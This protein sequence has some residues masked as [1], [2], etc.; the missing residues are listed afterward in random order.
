MSPASDTDAHPAAIKRA[1]L[2]GADPDLAA[3]L[4]GVLEP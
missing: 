3:F 4:S 2:V 1:L